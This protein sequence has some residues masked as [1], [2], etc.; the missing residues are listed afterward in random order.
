M[1]DLQALQG[2][3]A[4]EAV[5]TQRNLRLSDPEVWGTACG[6]LTGFR[7]MGSGL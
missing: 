4:F 6:P 1:V 5:H 7:N 3:A 2:E